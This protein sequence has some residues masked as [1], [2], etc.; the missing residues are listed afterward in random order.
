MVRLIPTPEEVMDILKKTGAY[1]KGH[2]VYPSGKHSAHYFQ[3]PLAFRYYDNARV[4]AV[5]LSRLF[6]VE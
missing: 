5:A 1:R 6:R 2:F 3:M 4:L